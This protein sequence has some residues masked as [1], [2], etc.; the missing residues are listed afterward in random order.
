MK[1]RAIWQVALTTPPGPLAPPTRD[2]AAELPLHFRKA[3]AINRVHADLA[4][5]SGHDAGPRRGRAGT[6][7]R[8]AAE[9]RPRPATAS[10]AQATQIAGLLST[11]K[12]SQQQRREVA[13]VAGIRM[14]AAGS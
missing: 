3:G 11:G 14:P 10:P 9:L 5:I 1:R 6:P 7:A 4:A 12:L 2:G 13:F 8:P